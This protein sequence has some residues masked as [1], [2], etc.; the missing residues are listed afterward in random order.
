MVSNGILLK[1]LAFRKLGLRNV[2][3]VGLYRARLNLGLHP[4]QRI[5]HIVAGTEFFGCLDETSV[6]LP[7]PQHWSQAALYFGWFKQELNGCPPDWHK[8][9]FTGERVQGNGKPWW[10]LSDFGTEAGD[11][12]A[13]WEASRFDWVLAKAQRAIAGHHGEVD[14]LNLWLADWCQANPCY[15]GPNWK[16]GQEAS[17]RVLHL[18]VA[19]R[20]LRQERAA[21]RDLIQLVT[22]HLARIKPTLG[23]AIA[24]DNNHGTSEA[25]ALFVGGHWC[26]VHE[27]IHGRQWA[28]SGRRWLEERVGRLILPD[29]SFS[30]YSVN[31]HRLVLDTLCIAELWRRWFDL[32]PF[33]DAFYSRAEL[34]S[35]WLFSLVD[36]DTGDVPNLG[37]N[38]GARLLPLTNADFRDYRPTVQLAMVLFAQ[39]KAFTGQANHEAHLRW[40]GVTAPS[41][42]A[43]RSRL[44]QYDHGGYIVMDRK[45]YWAL[46]RYPRYRFRPGHCDALHIDLWHQHRNV[47]RDDGTYSY[48]T[49]G[50]WDTYFGGTRAHN[51]IQFDHRDA[52]PR[53]G[54]FLRGAWLNAPYVQGPKESDGQQSFE[55]GYVDWKGA[56]HRRE[57]SLS[58]QQVTI[59][60]KIDGFKR[61]AILRW[62]LIPS[63]W[64]IAGSSVV[65]TR[66]ALDIVSNVPLRRFEIVEGWES[67]YYMRITALPVLEV[68]LEKPGTITTNVRALRQ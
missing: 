17:I 61:N 43:K 7:P 58:P 19:A 15:K 14:S 21:S 47:L 40:L 44:A 48:N 11:I 64:K 59:V 39:E 54:H 67:R 4:V 57:V 20:L 23:Y 29:G 30:Q 28:E 45:P 38:D 25:A 33:T 56:S 35:R 8:N 51:T 13:V 18:A 66:F 27:V 24:Q 16:C 55:A 37:A 26:D 10:E 49:E 42:A 31:Y 6:N 68:E 60:D 2:F 52:M 65:S 36:H 12:K 63:D 53:V 22:A 34:A 1:P 5:R 46:F 41:S 50:D 62:R 9:P 32:P 3:R